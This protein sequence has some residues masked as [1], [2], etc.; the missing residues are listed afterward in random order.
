MSEYLVL[1]DELDRPIGQIEKMAAHAA[2]LLHRAFSVVVFNDDR[3]VL[4]QRRA[5]GKYHSPGLW[6]NTCCGHPRPNERTEDAARRRLQ[7][8]MGF[9]CDL[10]RIGAF[11]YRAQFE[12]GLTEHE[13]DHVFV[14]TFDGDVQPNPEEVGEF[15]WMHLYELDDRLAND[16]SHYTY[17]FKKIW[18]LYAPLF[19]RIIDGDSVETR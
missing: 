12:N 7:E 10:T 8:E 15:Q 14:G 4:L 1:V 3:Q 16:G 17:W 5:E 19:P 13:I 9:A 2:G 11:K 18:E 6:S